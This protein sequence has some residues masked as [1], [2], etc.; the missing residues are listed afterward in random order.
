[1]FGKLYM[2]KLSNIHEIHEKLDGYFEVKPSVLV[3]GDHFRYT[4]NNYKD[5]GRK[6]SYGIV[7]ETTPGL[8]VRGYK[9]TYAPWT[10]DVQ[11]PYKELRFYIKDKTE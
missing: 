8:K 2:A 4:Q 10:L 5:V 9:S 3:V 1:M 6:C 7:T 11:N